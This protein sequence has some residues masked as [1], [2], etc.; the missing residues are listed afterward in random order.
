MQTVDLFRYDDASGIVVTPNKHNESDEPYCYRLIAD[1]GHLLMD[2]E[3]QTPCVD[4]HDPEIWDEV[5]D[6]T[7]T[8]D[9]FCE[10]DI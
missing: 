2:G 1:E 5:E 6:E 7:T 9:E 10:T 8:P 3:S 4:T